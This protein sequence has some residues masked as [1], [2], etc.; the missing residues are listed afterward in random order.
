MK[1]NIAVIGCGHWGK[2]LIRNFYE[3][4]ALHS[5]CDLDTEAA[6][7]IANKYNVKNLSFKRVIENEDIQG[8]VLAVPAPMHAKFGM[9]AIK[10]GKDV[11]I[12]KP[13]ATNTADAIKLIDESKKQNVQ[14]MV[15]HLTIPSC[16]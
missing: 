7:C 6:N 15:G 16:I 14:L 12:E 8:V 4:G 11:F 9:Q 1:K 13:L 10:A 5:I 3:L 2:N